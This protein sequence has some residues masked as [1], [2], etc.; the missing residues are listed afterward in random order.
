MLKIILPP[1]LEAAAAR[2]AVAVR[3]E[4]N[5]GTGP[6]DAALPAL[7][8]I[9][10]LA[11]GPEVPRFV[12]LTRA[13]LRTLVE[14]SEGQPFVYFASRP[15]DPIAWSGR[16][17][18]GV[19]ELLV[20]PSQPAAALAVEPPRP[21]PTP[22]P[23]EAATAAT[24]PQVDGSEHFLA[25]T[26][27]S[28]GHH[29]YDELLELLKGQGF[30]LETSNRRWWLRD[31]HKTLAFLGEHWTALK[32]CGAD[33]TENFQR[34]TARIGRAEIVAE[35]RAAGDDFDVTLELRA[36]DVDPTEVYA[37]VSSGR[38]FV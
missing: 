25:I 18:P 7:G 5:P 34:N 20:A 24:P 6:V 28:R 11:P 23:R 4:W 3:L 13:Q 32:D 16:S 35:A 15:A 33:F 22:T 38:S 9:Q 21:A 17:L 37:Q 30:T 27:P 2:D 29:A 8:V 14:A 31:R 1:N 26:L 19:T 10:R 12:Q 36:G